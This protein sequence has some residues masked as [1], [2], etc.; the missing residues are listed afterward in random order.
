MET[1]RSVRTRSE[2]STVSATE[3]L[4]GPERSTYQAVGPTG[5][6][7]P[8]FATV[9]VREPAVSTVRGPSKS[10]SLAPTPG[11]P[12]AW[13]VIVCPS[14]TNVSSTVTPVELSEM[15]TAVGVTVSPA[16]FEVARPEPLPATPPAVIRKA[17][18]MPASRTSGPIVSRRARV[19]APT[20]TATARRP[21]PVVTSWRVMA[22]LRTAPETGRAASSESRRAPSGPRRSWNVPAGAATPGVA[23]ASDTGAVSS[24]P[25]VVRSSSKSA[26]RVASSRPP[27]PP[28]VTVAPLPPVTRDVLAPGPPVPVSVR[29]TPSNVCP[30]TVTVMPRPT[31]VTTPSS[32]SRSTTKVPS[33]ETPGTLVRTE[34]SR[35]PVRSSR[36]RSSSAASSSRTYSGASSSP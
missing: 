15:A 12:R 11:G 20:A 17:P 18:A 32:E 24:A 5:P 25:D 33:N 10:R 19:P 1:P 26:R 2:P 9:S 28:K 3:R 6:A 30:A 34:P 31:A 27:V 23:G 14:T 4:A 13:T 7:I 36:V 22:P 29:S 35:R 16:T 21:W 8:A